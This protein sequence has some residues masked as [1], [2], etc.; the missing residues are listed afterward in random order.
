MINSTNWVRNST[1]GRDAGGAVAHK[2]RVARGLAAAG[3][4]NRFGARIAQ[5]EKE[6]DGREEMFH[7]EIDLT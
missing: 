5:K 4:E 6:T 1:E 7:L 3:R 2:R